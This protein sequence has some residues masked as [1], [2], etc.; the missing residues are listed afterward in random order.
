M[1]IAPARSKLPLDALKRL[2]R[3]ALPAGISAAAA[4]AAECEEAY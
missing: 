4:V 1:R 2:E 3:P